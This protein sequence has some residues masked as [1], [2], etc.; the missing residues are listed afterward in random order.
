MPLPQSIELAREFSVKLDW[1]FAYPK[2]E[3]AEA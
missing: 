1:L 2:S 3:K